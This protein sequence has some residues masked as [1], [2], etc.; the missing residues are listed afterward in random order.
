MKSLNSSSYKSVIWLSPFHLPQS[1]T[2]YVIF[3]PNTVC[4][5]KSRCGKQ[6]G[7]VNCWL[8]CQLSAA[9]KFHF[10]SSKRSGK[11]GKQICV[12]LWSVVTSQSE[13]C[14]QQ[15]S[16]LVPYPS[17]TWLCCR[18]QPNSPNSGKTTQIRL[19]GAHS[20]VCRGCAK[21]ETRKFTKKIIFLEWKEQKG[22]LFVTCSQNVA[23]HLPELGSRG[24]AHR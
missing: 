17:S 5:G 9:V 24:A 16:A 18:T 10:Q 2:C 11:N 4:C 23:L 12:V 7:A 20:C 15:L 3:Y 19:R 21:K 1:P 6:S 14:Q 13:P 22:A 8:S